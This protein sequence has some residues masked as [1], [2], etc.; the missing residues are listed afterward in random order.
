MALPRFIKLPGHYIF[1]YKP[2]YYDAKKEEREKK[3]KQF[4]QELGLE[5]KEEYKSDIKGQFKS[6]MS[7]SRRTKKTSNITL[8]FLIA[9]LGFVAY[10]FF[11]TDS[12]SI[13]TEMFVKY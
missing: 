2:M 7:Y 3:E 12:L 4:K 1:D 6:R 8:L 11:Y 5:T 10:L 13:I 9:F